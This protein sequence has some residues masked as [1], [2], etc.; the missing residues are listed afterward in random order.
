ME[1]PEEYLVVASFHTH[2]AFEYDTPAEFP[3]VGS[4]EVDEAEGV[5]GYILTSGGRFWYVDGSEPEVSQICG[6]G[7]TVTLGQ[8]EVEARDWHHLLVATICEQ[9]VA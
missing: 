3:S 6:D 8:L 1:A 2:C 7:S 5:D 4:V 9:V